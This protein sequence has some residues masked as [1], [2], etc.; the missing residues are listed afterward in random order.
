MIQSPEQQS[1]RARRQQVLQQHIDGENS[2]DIDAMIASFYH[3][4]YKVIP[5]A[6][7]DGE[8]AVRAA[9]HAPRR[10]CGYC[11]GPH[12]RH[13]GEGMGGHSAAR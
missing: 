7:S 2:K 9:R 8:A 5:M 1:L 3:P 12:D 13:S 11:R 10:Q 4:H 6:V